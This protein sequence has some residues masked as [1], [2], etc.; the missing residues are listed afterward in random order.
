MASAMVIEHQN[1]RAGVSC[2]Y[3]PEMADVLYL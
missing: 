1:V 2:F 3:C